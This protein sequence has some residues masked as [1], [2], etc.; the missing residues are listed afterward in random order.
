M[1]PRQTRRLP[2]TQAI[3][4]LPVHRVVGG[5]QAKIARLAEKAHQ[6]GRTGRSI[7][8][9]MFGIAH[10]PIMTKSPNGV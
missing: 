2:F 8:V 4:A 5:C 3:P 7:K 10:G 9:R 1:R 6:R